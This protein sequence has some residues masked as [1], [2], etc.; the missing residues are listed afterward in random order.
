MNEILISLRNFSKQEIPSVLN[1]VLIAI[2]IDEHLA[3]YEK[4]SCLKLFLKNIKKS[5]N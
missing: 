1:F 5:V 3:D 2:A 4:N